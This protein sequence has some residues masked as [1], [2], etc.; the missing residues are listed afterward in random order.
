[1]A[2]P[3]Y[4]LKKLIELETIRKYINLLYLTNH[5]QNGILHLQFILSTRVVHTTYIF[6]NNFFKTSTHFGSVI[7][8]SC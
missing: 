6:K 4:K 7:N 2:I 3:K 8:E 1:M 5:L